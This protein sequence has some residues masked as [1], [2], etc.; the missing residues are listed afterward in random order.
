MDFRRVIIAFIIICLFSTPVVFSQTSG[1]K[2]TIDK[3]KVKEKIIPNDE[4]QDQK[5]AKT[6]KSQIR[7][8]P[9]TRSKTTPKPPGRDSKI[10]FEYNEF[11]FG[12]VPQSSKVTHNFKVTN[13]GKD[14]LLIAK[15][16]GG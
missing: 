3:S 4:A 8:R 5:K 6:P 2:P 14:S 15:V 10:T 12:F 13:T 1:D 11:D 7:K 9:N 16:K